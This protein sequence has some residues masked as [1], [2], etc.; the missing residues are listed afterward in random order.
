MGLISG[1]DIT[2]HF[3]LS[4]GKLARAVST[5]LCFNMEF[6]SSES[7][8]VIAEHLAIVCI[9]MALDQAMGEEGLNMSVERNEG[10][11][12]SLMTLKSPSGRSLRPDGAIRGSDG[13]RMLSKVKSQSGIIPAKSCLT[14]LSLVVGGQAWQS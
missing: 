11:G 2:H 7:F 13:V 6:S 14:N 9:L 1:L 10:D 3:I 4:T 8:T 5:S 12:A